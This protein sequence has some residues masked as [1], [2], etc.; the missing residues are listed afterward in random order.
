M[1]DF[2]TRRTI[3]SVVDSIY[4]ASIL[5]TGTGF[6]SILEHSG[7]FWSISVL[8]GRILEQ[9]GAFWNILEHSGAFWST[10]TLISMCELRVWSSGEDAEDREFNP[11]RS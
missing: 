3:G 10:C 2:P 4:P 1:Y 9:S 8:S 7:A 5:G 11:H 6:K